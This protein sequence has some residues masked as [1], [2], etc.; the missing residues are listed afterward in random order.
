MWKIRIGTGVPGIDRVVELDAGISAGPGG[1]ADLLP[2]IAGL[3]GLGN[4]AVRAAD[5]L[6][7]GVVAHGLQETIC[8][9]DRVV[10]VLTRHGQIGVGVPIRVIGREFDGGEAL[11]GILQDALHISFRDRAF[12]GFADRLLQPRIFLRVERVR[13]RP[14]PGPDRGKYVI[15]PRLVHLGASNQ[16]GDLLLFDHLPVDELLDVRVIHVADHHLRCS[17]GLSRLI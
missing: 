7:I 12:L 8:H 16:R 10:G 2:Q 9:A 17:T 11:L 1:V 14:I 6:P 3:D 5:K 15:E 13:F 4:R